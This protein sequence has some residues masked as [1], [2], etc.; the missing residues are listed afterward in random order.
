MKER[1]N[2]AKNMRAFLAE[3]SERCF[4]SDLEESNGRGFLGS[5]K[6]KLFFDREHADGVNDPLGLKFIL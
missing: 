4:E 5:D 1:S 6:E 3:R 2:L